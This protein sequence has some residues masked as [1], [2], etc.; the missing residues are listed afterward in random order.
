[1]LLFVV[2]WLPLCGLGA[3]STITERD[4]SAIYRLKGGRFIARDEYE[5]RKLEP[6]IEAVAFRGVRTNQWPPGMVA[7]FQ[8]ERTNRYE[9]RRRPLRGQANYTEPLFFAFPLEDEEDAMKLAGHWE[10]FAL[11]HGGTKDYPAFEFAVEGEQVSGRFDQNTEYRYADIWGGT[12]RSNRL[13][14][15]VDYMNEF[16]FLDGE[17]SGGKIK[18]TWRRGDNAEKGPW[19]ATRK[20][21]MAPMGQLVPLYEWRRGD[22]RFYGITT[23]GED[24]MRVERPLCRVWRPVP[25]VSVPSP[26]K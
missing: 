7:I 24:W 23:P 25:E 9:L 18:G 1:M 3:E 26:S 4:L 13:E 11:R 21:A 14:L 16:W 22:A 19:E 17:L 10:G 15:R 6:Q 12:L 2:S 5:F 20:N 8:V